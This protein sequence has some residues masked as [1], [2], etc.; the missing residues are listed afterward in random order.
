[1]SDGILCNLKIAVQQSKRQMVVL[2]EEHRLRKTVYNGEY[3]CITP[4]GGQSSDENHSNLRPRV[5]TN[6][7][8]T[9]NI[10]RS[11][12]NGLT[13]GACSRSRQKQKLRSPDTSSTTR[14][15]EREL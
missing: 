14:S 5:M 10:R 9:E 12:M 3:N 13:S 6:E 8:R 15:L 11:L 2:A 4:R 7:K 1:M